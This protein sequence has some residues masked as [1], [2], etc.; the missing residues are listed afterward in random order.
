[1]WVL[2]IVFVALK[3]GLPVLRLTIEGIQSASPGADPQDA[4]SV[5]IDR[6]DA[7][8]TKA[9]GVSGVVFEAGKSG[10]PSI[11]RSSI[12]SIEPAIV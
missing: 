7:I 9:L 10:C 1:M 3:A 11:L 8:A 12:K 6:A 2:R 5:F 4:C